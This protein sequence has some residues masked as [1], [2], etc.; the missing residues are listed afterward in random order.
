MESSCSRNGVDV[1][2]TKNNS[3]RSF[4]PENVQRSSNALKKAEDPLTSCLMA[5]GGVTV[6]IYVARTS[7]NDIKIKRGV[8]KNKYKI[9]MTLKNAL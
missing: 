3:H 7:S 1:E 8:T 9:G 2:K 4:S 5:L 6:N